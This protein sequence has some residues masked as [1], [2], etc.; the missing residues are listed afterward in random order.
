MLLG[1]F[2]AGAVGA[3]E[4]A[5][6]WREA[7][8][9]KRLAEAASGAEKEHLERLYRTRHFEMKYGGRAAYAEYQKERVIWKRGY[10]YVLWVLKG[11]VQLSRYLADAK[12]Q[13]VEARVGKES[14][15]VLLGRREYI[16]REHEKIMIRYR[17]VYW[18]LLLSLAPSKEA[19]GLE[20]DAKVF[21][22]GIDFMRLAVA[23]VAEVSKEI[24]KVDA[25]VD[26]I[27]PVL[28]KLPRTGLDDL[29]RDLV[30]LPEEELSR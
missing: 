27:R 3:E 23:P 15:E 20:S 8:E 12:I 22:N 1:L 24:A 2:S 30:A 26:Q 13:E 21:Y 11:Q 14:Y 28:Q 5:E 19:E 18:P 25:F 7:E 17:D 29:E 4:R 10:G 6:L 16:E 9:L